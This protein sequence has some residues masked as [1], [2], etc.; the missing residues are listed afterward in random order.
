MEEESVTLFIS[1]HGMEYFDNRYKE[2]KNVYL[3]SFVG[4]PGLSNFMY[5]CPLNEE[6]PNTIQQ[7]EFVKKYY[8]DGLSKGKTQKNFFLNEKVSKELKQGLKNIDERLLIKENKYSNENTE[9]YGKESSYIHKNLYS[10]A[11]PINLYSTTIPITERLYQLNPNQYENYDECRDMYGN[12]TFIKDRVN[13]YCPEYGITIVASTNPKDNG[14]TLVTAEDDIYKN[15]L[16][17]F[18]SL[19]TTDEDKEYII[20]EKSNINLNKST[21]EHWRKRAYNYSPTMFNFN[22]KYIT[23]DDYIDMLI[24][25]IF[26]KKEITLTE[27]IYL[28]ESMGFK[29]IY[30]LDPT[31][32]YSNKTKS[33]KETKKQIKLEK[34][35]YQID[36]NPLLYPETDD[37]N[38]IQSVDNENDNVCSKLG[39]C[40]KKCVDNICEWV[41]IFKTKISGGKTKKINKKIN[42]LK[43]PIRYL[44]NK[45]SK[46]DK[47]EQIKMLIK[48]KKMYKKN[49]YYTRKKLDSY[50]NKTSKH[51]IHAR[52]IYNVKEIVPNKELSLKTG[53]SIDALNKI[54]KKGQGA[55]Y[56]SGSRPNQTSQSWGLA[57]LASSITAGKAA[58]VDYDILEKGCNHKKTAYILANKAKQKYKFGRSKTKKVKI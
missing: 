18:K 56:S 43:F 57:R 25:Y 33:S 1:G 3:M 58:A 38:E 13:P 6:A 19:D 26:N 55:Y 39:N 42:Q 12:T 2:N 5:R 35:N 11:F 45:L 14:Y 4:V 27:L 47:K 8:K 37:V 20:R 40:V 28:F 46:K 15:N 22:G 34:A 50:K 36:E 31:C 9:L 30:I 48:S 7:L 41:P 10:P 32:R 23:H 52:K 49:E 24:F 17:N 54:V 44:P 16:K 53:C 29:K 21:I 51:I